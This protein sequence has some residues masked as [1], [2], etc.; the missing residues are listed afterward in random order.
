LVGLV[1]NDDAISELR[2]GHVGDVRLVQFAVEVESRIFEHVFDFRT[3][4]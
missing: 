2:G 1:A 4:P 3:G